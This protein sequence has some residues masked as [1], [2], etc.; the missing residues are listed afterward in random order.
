MKKVFLFLVVISFF[1]TAY[2]IIG[3]GSYQDNGQSVAPTFHNL[4]PEYNPFMEERDVLAALNLGLQDH[5]YLDESDVQ[6]YTTKDQLNKQDRASRMKKRYYAVTHYKPRMSTLG[7]SVVPPPGADWYE[8]L[9][10]NALVYVKINEMHKR[11]VIFTEAREVTLSKKIKNQ[12]EL[13][14][15]VQSSKN[16]KVDSANWKQYQLTVDAAKTLPGQCVRYSQYYQDYG[17]KGVDDKK[18]VKVDTQ[19]IFCLHPDNS[20]LAIDLSYIEKTL[21]NTQ[22]ASFRNEGET[23]LASLRFH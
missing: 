11:Y 6:A 18:Y 10:N 15:Y 4:E 3:P 8:N 21:S 12:N 5:Q 19:G 22:V 2:F 13:R 7:F 17:M 14:A 9:K 1:S 23:F 20:R 16:K